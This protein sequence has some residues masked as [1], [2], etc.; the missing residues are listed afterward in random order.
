MTATRKPEFSVWERASIRTDE[1]APVTL[2]LHAPDGGWVK[3]STDSNAILVPADTVAMRFN[4]AAE[5][6]ELARLCE[7][8]AKRL[9]FMQRAAHVARG[10]SVALICR[11]STC[12]A[13]RA[14]EPEH[15]TIVLT[16]D[17]AKGMREN[18]APTEVRIT[19]HRAMHDFMDR[20]EDELGKAGF[21]AIE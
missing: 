20:R 5:L 6:R 19:P 3:D 4:D 8:M 13:S 10:G 18:Y 1:A 14:S 2:E 15:T 21:P 7:H 9:E 11:H 16:N 12:L 17:E